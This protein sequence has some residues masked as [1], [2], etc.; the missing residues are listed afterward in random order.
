MGLI[1]RVRDPTQATRAPR[2]VGHGRH[3]LPTERREEGRP[4]DRRRLRPPLDGGKKK[5]E[6]TKE[7][8]GRTQDLDGT[9][10]GGLCEPLV[11]TS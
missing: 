1:Q 3:K 9:V 11:G 2:G 7:V 10:L 8:L 4:L 5:A 6:G